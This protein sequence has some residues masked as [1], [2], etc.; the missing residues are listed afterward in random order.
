MRIDDERERIFQAA[1]TV[2]REDPALPI[3]A[4]AK[5]ARVSRATVYRYTGGRRAL[6]DALGAGVPEDARAR[7]IQA[8]MKALVDV[9]L[10]RVTVAN[11]AAA[12]GVAPVT[13]YRIFG[14]RAGLLAAVGA[15]AVGR[16]AGT[17]L[18]V[19][20]SDD[21]RADLVAFVTPVLTFL[22]ENN[23]GMLHALVGAHEAPAVFAA[24]HPEHHTRTVDRVAAY[25]EKQRTA[26]RVSANL[27]AKRAA[28]ALF[29]LI[30]GFAVLAPTLRLGDFVQND[31]DGA[32]HY[33]VDVFLGGIMHG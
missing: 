31:V 4:V 21:V 19:D 22:R 6:L 5:L 13:V 11:I 8:A 1:A 29:S 20:A 32:A 16:R 28:V 10:H 3:D 15:S 2:W 7:I 27:D 24:I 12:A 25:L 14:D 30:A 33:I 18:Q 9:G 26:G 23:R 17:Q